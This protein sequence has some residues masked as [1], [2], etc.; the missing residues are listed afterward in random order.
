MISLVFCGET[1]CSSGN[2]EAVRVLLE[3]GADELRTSRAKLRFI[4]LLTKAMQPQLSCYWRLEPTHR[5]RT[6][7]VNCATLCHLDVPHGH[8]SIVAGMGNRSQCGGRTSAA[9]N[10]R[11]TLLDGCCMKE[12]MSPQPTW[13][14]ILRCSSRVIFNA[15]P[16]LRCC[17]RTEMTATCK[18]VVWVSE[19]LDGELAPTTIELTRLA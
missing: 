7:R 9:L 6:C 12:Q 2:G 3:L 1:A 19:K 13:L 14:A 4:S 16:L 11:V 17:S 8:D 5:Q 18:R 15:R 10:G